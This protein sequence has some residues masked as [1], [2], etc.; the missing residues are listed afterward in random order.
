[1]QVLGQLDQDPGQLLVDPQE[2]AVWTVSVEPRNVTSAGDDQQQRI[3][4]FATDGSGLLQQADI[5]G[6]KVFGSCFLGSTFITAGWDATL[7]I[8]D[9]HRPMP[10]ATIPGS[11]PFRCV[12]AAGDRVV[13]GDQKGNVWFLAPMSELY[14]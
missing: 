3:A 12:D 11:S 5:T 14:P 2:T 1:M 7:R 8:W 6:H 10:L 4:A 13:A 9:P